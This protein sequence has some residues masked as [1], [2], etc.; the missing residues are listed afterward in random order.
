MR[1]VKFTLVIAL[2]IFIFLPLMAQKGSTLT[3]ERMEICTAVKEREPV[4]ADTSFGSNV[5][6]LYCFTTLSGA[7]DTTSVSHVWYYQGEEKANVNLNIKAKK[8]R[9]WSSKRI[10]EKWTGE[11]RVDVVTAEG[12]VLRSKEFMIKESE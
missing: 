1:K 2:S 4:G 10:M 9:T 7:K 8:W 3:V 6:Q 11:W 5:Q 12:T